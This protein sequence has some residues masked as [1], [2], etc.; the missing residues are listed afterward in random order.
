MDDETI[1]HI[2][3]EFCEFLF[4]IRKIKLKSFKK[5]INENSQITIAFK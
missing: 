5:V 4:K 2:S 1:P 3:K